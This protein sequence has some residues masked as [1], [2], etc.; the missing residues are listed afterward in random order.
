MAVRQVLSAAVGDLRL[1][2]GGTS[3]DGNAEFG[4]LEIFDGGGWGSVCEVGPV[5]PFS[6]IITNVAPFPEAS[7]D[8]ACRQLG[9]DGGAK[10]M[11]ARGVRSSPQQ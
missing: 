7:V 8:V 3:N 1:T 4:S 2:R 6:G 10:I 11:T 5:G 9:F